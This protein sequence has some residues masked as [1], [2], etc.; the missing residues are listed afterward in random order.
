[1]SEVPSVLVN[2]PEGKYKEE[3]I[4]KFDLKRSD[5]YGKRSMYKVVAMI[6]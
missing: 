1:M 6:I 3:W 4:W 2:L 5:Y